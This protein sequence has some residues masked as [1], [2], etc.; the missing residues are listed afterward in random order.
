MGG[1]SNNQ[2][3]KKWDEILNVM[4]IILLIFLRNCMSV[5]PKADWF[6]F[7]LYRKF[8][9][10]SVTS[11]DMFQSQSHTMGQFKTLDLVG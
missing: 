9:D 2:T 1:N 4:I 6:I 3:P 11:M 10:L 5:T 7:F 8:G